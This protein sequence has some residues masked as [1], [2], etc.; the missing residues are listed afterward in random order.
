MVT[1]TTTSHVAFIIF[2]VVVTTTSHVALPIFCLAPC[3]AL[4]FSERFWSTDLQ[5]CGNHFL[6]WFTRFW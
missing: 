3:S 1:V 2:L 6:V 5:I 4:V